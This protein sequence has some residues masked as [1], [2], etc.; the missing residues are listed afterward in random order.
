MNDLVPL[1][2]LTQWQGEE[3]FLLDEE[4]GNGAVVGDHGGD[5]A[6]GA[7]GLVEVGYELEFASGEESEC[8][9]EACEQGNEAKVLSQGAEKHEEREHEPCDQV[10]SESIVELSGRCGVRLDDTAAWDQDSRVAHPEGTVGR[11]CG[12]TENVSTGEFP[13]SSKELYETTGENRHA[14]DDVGR[15]DAAS[16]D[17]DEGED[18]SR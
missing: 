12:G 14:Y 13:H 3:A 18:E 8:D 10:D 16:L 2:D 6:H 5:D 17:I 11:E 15:G 9:T 4:L 1:G 7:S